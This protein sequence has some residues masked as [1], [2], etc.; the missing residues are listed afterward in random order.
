MGSTILDR[1]SIGEG[2]VVGA[3]AVVTRD[4]APGTQVLGLPARPVK[5]GLEG[6]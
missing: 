3:G 1:L 6:R 4:V 2:A 5:E